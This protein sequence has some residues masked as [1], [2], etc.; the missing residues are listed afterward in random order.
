MVRDHTD[1]PLADNESLP[2]VGLQRN[3]NGWPVDQRR[4]TTSTVEDLNF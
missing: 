4:K 1:N 2:Q 3:T